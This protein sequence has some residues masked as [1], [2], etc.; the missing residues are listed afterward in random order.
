MTLIN[1][2]KKKIIFSLFFLLL[3]NSCTFTVD[4]FNKVKEIKLEEMPLRD[5]IAQMMI[6]EGKIENLEKVSKLNIGGVFFFAL[7]DYNEYVNLIN[8]FQENSKHGLFVATDLEGCVNMLENVQSFKY[9]NEVENEQEAFELGRSMGALMKDLGFNLNFA[10][11][12]DLE[13][14]IW[15]C[16]SFVGTTEEIAKKGLAFLEGLQGEGVMGTSK[17]FPGRTLNVADTHHRE[18]YASISGD[19]LIPFYAAIEGNSNMIMV[20]HLVVNGEIDSN[21]LPSSLSLDVIRAIKG[22]GF[23][24]FIVTDDLRMKGVSEGYDNKFEIYIDAITAGNDLLLNVYENNP[25]KAIDYIEKAV[26]EGRVD[27]SKIDSAVVKIL[28]KKGIIVI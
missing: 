19:D 27:I 14:T 24:G 18:A 6:I 13:D 22:K 7:E 23:N 12:L 16:R 9:F 8:R 2:V 26:L 17:H 4:N 15:N 20:N 5:K 1:F 25:D 11:V 10:P 21:G 28:G 3:I